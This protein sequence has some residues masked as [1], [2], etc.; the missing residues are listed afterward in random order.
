M[1]F[2]PVVRE[3]ISIPNSLIEFS[4]D[5]KI[6]IKLLDF[7]LLSYE[8]VFK[9]PELEEYK[10][11]EKNSSLSEN[12]LLDESLKIRQEY[13]IKIMPRKV[14]TNPIKIKFAT[15]KFK[16]KAIVTILKGSI[17]SSGIDLQREI[18]DLIWHKK[19]RAGLFINL[20]ESVFN[21]QLTKL[22]KLVPCDK[23][24]PKDIKMT[25][26]LGVEPTIPID[27]H[28]EKLYELKDDDSKS[29]IEGIDKD[30]LILKY[31]L[32]KNGSNGRACDGKYIK[33]REAQIIDNKPSIDDSINFKEFDDYIEYYANIDGYVT[34]NK[35]EYLISNKLTLDG[36]DFKS[37]GAI[38]T[39]E[40][41][42]ISVHIGHSKTQSEDAIGS[43]VNIEVK[44]LSV[45][46]SI[47]SNVNISTQ[48]LNVDAQTHSNSTLEVAENATVK[49]H[50]GDL[51][52][53]NAEVDILETGKVS[54]HESITINKMLGGQAIAPIV[55]VNE[56]LSNC[57]I[58][59]SELIEIKSINGSNIN[60][61][62]NPDA[63]E[64]YH[65]NLEE[66]KIRDKELKKELTILKEKFEKDAAEHNSQIDRI[67]TFKLRILKAQKEGKTPMKQD[68]LR[69]KEYK[70]VSENLTTIKTKIDDG[71]QELEHIKNELQRM[72]DLEFH[73]KI[74]S[75]SNYDGHINVKFVS[76]KTKEET[77][78]SPDGRVDNISLIV[79]SNGQ[80]VISLD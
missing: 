21:T 75:Q 10:I 11:L 53:K 23:K 73:A 38:D 44:E 34:S 31:I 48:N 13:S 76:P 79:N 64:S 35:N 27:A 62:I 15:N 58:I 29:I 78:Y 39:G 25:V 66:L 30:E 46:G 3:S 2:T 24:L 16:T 45:D 50:R 57:T 47:G 37:T 1:Q 51:V 18:K 70:R 52:A 43:G 61:I 68:A 80:R 19:L 63:I 26:A 4:K 59:A 7:E 42:D 77:N 8:T 28:I 67:K 12:E 49:L 56:L 5:R 20:F 40:D 60:L 9:T 55:R 71:D 22:L 32:A 54:A 36:A 14:S 69:I 65:K 74:T 41:K 72:Y 33:I 6:D 17:F